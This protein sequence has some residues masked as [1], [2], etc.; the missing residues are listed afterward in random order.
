[1]TVKPATALPEIVY[2]IVI[3]IFISASI[4]LIVWTCDCCFSAYFLMV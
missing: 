1:L 3:L 4:L 2:I